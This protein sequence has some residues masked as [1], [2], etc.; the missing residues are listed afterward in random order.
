[1]PDT[2]RPDFRGQNFVAEASAISR[3]YVSV[4]V[5]SPKN[6]ESVQFSPKADL[7]LVSSL[8]LVCANAGVCV[9][10]TAHREVWVESR[11]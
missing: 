6:K 10:A 2:A 3:F 9:S 5:P 7:V 1:M 8:L 11:T 4:I